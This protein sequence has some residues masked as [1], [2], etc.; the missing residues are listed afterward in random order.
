AGGEEGRGG[1][2]RGGPHEGEPADGADD[3]RDEGGGDDQRQQRDEFRDHGRG[4]LQ[5]GGGADH[6]RSRRPSPRDEPHRRAGERQ[7]HGREQRAEEP[8]QGQ[9]DQ[10]RGKAAGD[11]GG[12]RQ[13]N[14]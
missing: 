8:R 14:R 10:A 11:A 6:D 5:T 2:A 1:V 12:K 7:R 13:A 4:E 9:V 3:G